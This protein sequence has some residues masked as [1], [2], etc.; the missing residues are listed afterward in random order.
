MK[1]EE[2]RIG[3]LWEGFDAFWNKNLLP[4]IIEDYPEW[5]SEE[6]LSKMKRN[7]WH[8]WVEDARIDAMN[9]PP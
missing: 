3:E 5:N 1:A 7:C 4:L 8:G 2:K 6:I 9:P